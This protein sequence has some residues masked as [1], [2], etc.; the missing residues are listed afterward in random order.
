MTDHQVVTFMLRYVLCLIR[1]KLSLLTTYD[2]VISA[3]GPMPQNNYIQKGISYLFH[4]H[5]IF[6]H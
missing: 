3:L 2:V 5:T 4:G 6:T 1:I